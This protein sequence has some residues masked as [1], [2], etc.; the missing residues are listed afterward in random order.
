MCTCGETKPHIIATRTDLDGLHVTM[1]DDGAIT[2]ALG[3]GIKGV[4]IR[5][6][7]TAEQI[8]ATRRIGRLFMGEVC[9]HSRAE[10]PAVYAA[11]ERAA[12]IDGLPG[13]LRRIYRERAAPRFTLKWT[14][15]HADTR[16]QPVERSCR[17]PRMWWPG[18][19]VFDFCGSTGSARGR[20]QLWRDDKRDG[21]CT[22][23]GFQFAT[24]RDLHA[25]LD[26]IKAMH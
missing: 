1:W 12:K 10:L 6:P 11:A 26:S 8:E 19:V 13:T 15:E 18:L 7:K 2:G 14:V 16:G 3:I 24:M 9:I 4:P 20:Y 25:H 17:L 22:P 21:C 23:T 5:R